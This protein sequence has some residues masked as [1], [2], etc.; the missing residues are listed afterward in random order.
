MKKLFLLLIILP[1]LTGCKIMNIKEL[2]YGQS[3]AAILYKEKLP[4][5][6]SN[7]HNT[8]DFK[9]N[10]IK[11]TDTIA[12]KIGNQFG[13]EYKIIN[14]ENFSDMFQITWIFPKGMCDINGKP[15]KKIT[16]DTVKLT[17]EYSYSNYTLETDNELVKGKWTFVLSYKGRKLYEKSFILI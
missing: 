16:Y 13:V 14:D 10:I 11:R 8:T 2:N 1:A 5:S 9:L 15:L 12:A 4:N 17:N 6:P 3:N 7:N